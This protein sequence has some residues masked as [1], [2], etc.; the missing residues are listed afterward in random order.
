MH[1]KIG[2]CRKPE[3]FL[4]SCYAAIEVEFSQ[5][6]RKAPNF[7]VWCKK[8]L[9]KLKTP[10]KAGSIAIGIVFLTNLGARKP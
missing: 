7:F 6:E 2:F 5:K 3:Y 1:Q 9:I 4:P 8:Y 10:R